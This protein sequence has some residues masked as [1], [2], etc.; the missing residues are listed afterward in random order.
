MVVT[1]TA[2]KNISQMPKTCWVQRYRGI[3]R[4]EDSPVES[5]LMRLALS[6][7]SVLMEMTDI[8]Y[9]SDGVP[10]SK[11]IMPSFQFASWGLRR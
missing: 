9:V 2:R 10:A 4:G 3:R 1:V 7:T 5:C 11:A 8:R 6:L